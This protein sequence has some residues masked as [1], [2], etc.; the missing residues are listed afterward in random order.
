MSRQR[1][2]SPDR[3]HAAGNKRLAVDKIM[4]HGFRAL[5]RKGFDV[6]PGEEVT[7]KARSIK[8]PDEI[9][10]MRCASMP[11]RTAV[12]RWKISRAT[13]AARQY[14]RR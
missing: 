12:R 1:G 3:E 5:R 8:G 2:Q 7:E 13:C 10:A 4:L 6:M 9:M 14:L 11:A